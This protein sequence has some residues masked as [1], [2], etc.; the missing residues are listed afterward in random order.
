MCS[1]IDSPVQAAALIAP[2]NKQDPLANFDCTAQLMEL[3][4]RLLDLSLGLF[5][6]QY[7]KDSS[8]QLQLAEQG[9]MPMIANVV[10][11]LQAGVFARHSQTSDKLSGH[12]YSVLYASQLAKA[13]REACGNHTDSNRLVGMFLCLMLPCSCAIW[14]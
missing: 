3:A 5:Q 7:A 6:Q 12:S 9:T 4:G 14:C 1:N 11:Q 13:V 2:V 8:M 10:A